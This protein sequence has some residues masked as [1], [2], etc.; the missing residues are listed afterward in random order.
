MTKAPTRRTVLMLASA[1]IMVA[2]VFGTGIWV[3]GG[4]LS[5]LNAPT[6]ETIYITPEPESSPSQIA[7]ASTPT[8]SIVVS[9]SPAE[10]A[11]PSPT[12]TPTA[13]PTRAPT[14]RPP[15]PTPA[16]PNLEVHEIGYSLAFCN[17]WGTASAYVVNN[18]P[19][20]SHAVQITL[21]DTWG[22]HVP[23]SGG[24]TIPAL[25]PG[26]HFSANFNVRVTVGCG[27][28]HVFTFRIDPPGTLSE[29]RR[30]DNVRSTTHFVQL[31][32]PNLRVTGLRLS[33]SHPKCLLA[34][35]V[36]ATIAND[37]PLATSSTANL[38]VSDHAGTAVKLAAANIPIIPAHSTITTTTRLLLGPDHCGEMHQLGAMADNTDRIDEYDED[39]NGRS[40]S[41]TL[42]H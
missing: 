7:D 31:Y 3:G 38:L 39:D 21:T 6:P 12:D 2:S 26:G 14:L 11:S 28:D 10:F 5:F 37:G 22:D 25:A 16:L 19:G 24:L 8:P 40:L 36:I 27:H 15:T 17:E 9:P 30:D 34:F 29:T 13:S 41:Y 20:A 23:Y 42:E 18:G 1:I 35:D 32:L 4:G 33:T